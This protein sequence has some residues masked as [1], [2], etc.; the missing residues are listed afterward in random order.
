MIPPTGD[1]K[2][3]KLMRVFREDL[4]FSDA[5]HKEVDFQTLPNGSVKWTNG[6][7]KPKEVKVS[8]VVQSVIITLLT[9][10]DKEKTLTENHIDLWDMFVEK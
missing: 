9:D 3:L 1:I 4:S 7:I 5:E 8:P 6:K 2:S 10:M